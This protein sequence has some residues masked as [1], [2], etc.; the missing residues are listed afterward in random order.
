MIV[1]M[2][3]ARFITVER[4]D[5]FDMTRRLI[6]AV[7][8]GLLQDT[9]DPV[10]VSVIG[11]PNCGKKIVADA[12][13]EILFDTPPVMTGQSGH[14]EYWTGMRAGAP[15]EFHYM[16]SA[17]GHNFSNEE[18]NNRQ[19]RR[20]RI[21]I[22]KNFRQAGGMTVIQN[23]DEASNRDADITFTIKK[24]LFE[25]EQPY[26]DPGPDRDNGKKIVRRDKELMNQ[27]NAEAESHP[28]LRY[29]EV[30]VHNP[31]LLKSPQFREAFSS[32]ASPQPIL[33]VIKSAVM[34]LVHGERAYS[35]LPRYG[36]DIT[37]QA[38]EAP[39]P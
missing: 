6:G 32:L 27:F 14:D 37:R 12:A 28:W 20:E 35:S 31:R 39:A 36:R 25:I 17:Y 4:E 11:S 26:R 22:F 23:I 3:T 13:R 8:T 18:L 24:R 9:Q 15:M 29:V 30:E 33:E 21:D 34:A 19:C 16:D 7:E 2:I 5:L 1:P 10:L 38:I